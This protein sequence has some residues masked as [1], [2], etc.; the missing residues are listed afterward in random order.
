MS[1]AKLKIEDD[2]IRKKNDSKGKDKK[3]MHFFS[4]INNVKR[5]PERFKEKNR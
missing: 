4:H 5:N 2:R 1:C 3:W